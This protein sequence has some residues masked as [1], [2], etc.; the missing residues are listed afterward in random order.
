[1]HAS[2]DDIGVHLHLDHPHFPHC[3]Q[4][5]PIRLV[6]ELTLRPGSV[7]G[8][9]EARFPLRQR[10]HGFAR[11]MSPPDPRF[12]ARVA[13]GPATFADGL[14]TFAAG[15][16]SPVDRL[17]RLNSNEERPRRSHWIPQAA[18]AGVHRQERRPRRQP[19]KAV[20]SPPVCSS[21]VCSP[22][23]RHDGEAPGPTGHVSRQ[24]DNLTR[25]VDDLAGGARKGLRGRLTRS[26]PES[27]CGKSASSGSTISVESPRTRLPATC[28]R[29]AASGI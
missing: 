13:S 14:M 9:A 26:R 10:S 21:L 15:Q 3:K 11:Q 19:R 25:H 6:G 28:F 12:V 23:K 16:V 18:R 29:G 27:I 5:R 8:P 22:A 20:L 24:V 2:T 4:R 7:G 17:S 1:M